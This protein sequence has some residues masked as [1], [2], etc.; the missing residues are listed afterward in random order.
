MWRFLFE[1]ALFGGLKGKPKKKTHSISLSFRI[2]PKEGC[3]ANCCALTSRWKSRTEGLLLDPEIG[4]A[5][6]DS[7]RFRGLQV[8]AI[9]ASTFTVPLFGREGNPN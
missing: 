2:T 6:E 8:P 4:A 5:P 1:G 7:L 3:Q 9:G